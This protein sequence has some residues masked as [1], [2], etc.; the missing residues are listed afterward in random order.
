MYNRSSKKLIAVLSVASNQQP[1][2][3]KVLEDQDRWF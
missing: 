2:T 1:F 3:V